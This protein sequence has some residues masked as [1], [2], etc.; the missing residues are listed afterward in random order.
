MSE[1][2]GDDLNF[3]ELVGNLLSSH[4]ATEGLNQSME[5]VPET[6]EGSLHTEEVEEHPE[7]DLPVFGAEEE[8]LAAVVA[9]AIQNMNDGNPREDEEPVHFQEENNEQQQE[10]PQQE[11]LQADGNLPENDEEH[12]QN[13]EWAHMLQ[14][15]LM[16]GNEETPLNPED[17]LDQDDENLRRA[18]LESLQELNVKDNKEPPRDLPKEKKVKSKKQSKKSSSKKKKSEDKGS[19]KKKK[20]QKKD[21]DENLLNFEDVIRGFMHPETVSNQADL[22]AVPDVGDKETQALVEATLKAFER[23]LLGPAAINPKGTTS[24]SAA[25]KKSSSSKKKSSSK[26]SGEKSKSKT[27]KPS[28]FTSNQQRDL[29]VTSPARNKKKKKNHS[30][31]IE[32]DEDD[33]SKQLAEMVN[34]VVNTT[35]PPDGEVENQGTFRPSTESPSED[36]AG[37]LTHLELR[38]APTGLEENA[39]ETFDLN[40]IMQRAMNMAFQE[41]N[42]ENF[43]TSIMEEFNRGLAD[44]AVADL[45]TSSTA[46]SKKSSSAKHSHARSVSESEASKQAKDISSLEKFMKKKY[47]QV[48]L[49]AASAAKKR[50]SEKNKYNRQKLK[51]ERQK[52]RESKKSKKRE[53]RERLERERKELEDIVAKGPPYPP[54]LRLTKSGKPKKPYRRWTPE[55]MAKRASM[56]REDL[57]KSDKIKK[58]KKKKSRKL[59]RVPLYNLKNIPLFNFIKGN[60][61]NELRAKQKLNGIEDTLNKIHL[62]PRRLDINKLAP[63]D[64]M[65]PEQME[66]EKNA[67]DAD[68]DYVLNMLQRKTV[69]HRE[70]IL[71]H[72]PWALPAH[73]P[74]ALPVARRRR[75]EKSKGSKD[76]TRSRRYSGARRVSESMNV[77]NKIIP[78]VLLPIINTLKAAARAKAASGATSEESNKHLMSIIKH[79]KHTIAQ[80]LEGSKRAT[81]KDYYGSNIHGVFEHGDKK[82][83]RI[84]IFSLANIKKIDTSDKPKSGDVN[85]KQATAV[86]PLIKIEEGENSSSIP[87]SNESAKTPSSTNENE[88]ISG[89]D[90]SGGQLR[91][92]TSVIDNVNTKDPFKHGVPLG[93]A[94]PEKEE[95]AQ[96]ETNVLEKEAEVVQIKPTSGTD[97]DEGNNR[98]E[99][100]G[101]V[102]ATTLSRTSQSDPKEPEKVKANSEK[103]ALPAVIKGEPKEIPIVGLSH[104]TNGSENKSSEGALE[105]MIKQQLTQSHNESVDLPENLSGVLY[106]TLANII[107]G[108]NEHTK[109]QADIAPPR[110]ERKPYKKRPPPVLNLDGLV[111]PS[112]SPIIPKTEPK[113]SLQR[114]ASPSVPSITRKSRQKTD[115][116]TLLYTFNV[117]NFKE[118]QGRRTMLLK[119]AKEHLNAEE[120]AILK[121]EINKER[122]R[123]WREANV[124]KN[125]EHDLRARVKRRASSKFGEADSAEK[126]QWFENEVSKGLAERGIKQDETSKAGNGGNGSG[127]KNTGSSNLS[128][129]EVL[130]MIATAL[131][132]LDVARTLERELNEIHRP[133]GTAGNKLKK[134]ETSPPADT[135]TGLMEHSVL[136]EAQST[137]EQEKRESD[138]D[139][140][141]EDG[142]IKRPYPD[143][144]PVM[145]PILKR[146]KYLNA[147]G[148]S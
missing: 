119:R 33:F 102:S 52:M 146:P 19:S 110:P 138:N 17:Q 132:K 136:E 74:M 86:P 43:D 80:T 64:F 70:K 45:E 123:K 7:V 93:K 16:Q 99:Q 38:T 37:D 143:D 68:T 60:I 51:E 66:K 29:S 115:P 125:W 2:H 120:M 104:L 109:G 85:L 82:V 96:T 40:Q 145:V 47:S 57:H 56:P 101:S 41:Q 147:E 95:P 76:P 79:T 49:A 23:E 111:P 15:G 58:V 24:S 8:D 113:E 133:G 112:G 116:P 65:T 128:D 84:P 46:K 108:F 117:P 90:R 122:K 30:E 4:N 130:N 100:Q 31:V 114:S 69:V 25:R 81:N 62:Q 94:E 63:P 54:D 124:E 97:L 77:R 28:E 126:T 44:L 13:Q 36:V 48:A 75:K 67:N 141:D 106:A 53:E 21:D 39:D 55:E 26:K 137:V 20:H 1:D 42:G 105:D 78:A 3:N 118:M 73:P 103:T 59:K 83:R 61:S 9:S 127:R 18:I 12:Q 139:E 140:I 131:G 32:P 10:E 6:Q 34:Q 91:K 72:P 148:T 129:N 89:V 50:I 107:P 35:V 14:Q 87:H 5:G 22:P 27:Y 11:Q 121:K 144:V 134:I 71:F 92:D 98:T 142:H 88:E 135:H